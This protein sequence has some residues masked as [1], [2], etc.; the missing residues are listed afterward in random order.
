MVIQNAYPFSFRPAMAMIELIFAL[1]VMGIVLMSAPAL[2]STATKSS[3]I[4]I[5]QESINEAATQANIILTY[6]W[7]EANAEELG[8]EGILTSILNTNGDAKLA[9]SID[10]PRRAGTP[11]ESNRAAANPLKSATR[12][13]NL[14]RDGINE[15]IDDM[16][17]F[18]N[19]TT[20]LYKEEN[21]ASPG[22]RQSDY[23]DQNIQ[24]NISVQYINDNTEYNANTINF[25]PFT[26]SSQTS[27]IKHIRVQLTAAGDAA[28]EL[29]KSITLHAFSCN[30]GNYVLNERL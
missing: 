27:N 24:M 4:A 10:Q 13:Q 22:G 26:P 3:Y 29:S 17:D 5:Q 6:P 15:P 25:N 28:N 20:T 30:I 16:D 11:L 18:H 7:D 2:I 8:P 9:I 14:G 21:V 12:N 23:I 19:L 1:V